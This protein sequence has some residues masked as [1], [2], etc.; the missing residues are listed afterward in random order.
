MAVQF[1]TDAVA[2]AQR[3]AQWQDIVCDVYVQLDCK[4]DLG[5]AFRGAITRVPLG[6]AACSTVSSDRQRVLRTP[7]RIAHA[8]EDFVLI[9]LG[10]H[11]RGAVL[12]DG[13]EAVI[14]AG[15]YALYDTTRPYELQ[16]DDAF[17]QTILQVPRAMLHRRIGGWENFTAVSFAMRSPIERLAFDFIASLSRIAGDI[18]PDNADRVTDQAL[19][20]VAMAIS[21][22]QGAATASPSTHRAA[23]LYRLKAHI[24]SHLAEPD[25]SPSDVAAAFGISPRYVNN[26][27]ADEHT[28]FQR[29]LLEQRLERCRRDLASPAH[30]PRQVSEIAF[31]WGFNDLSHFARVFRA[32][33]DVSPRECRASQLPRRS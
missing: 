22:L 10:R 27:L 25:L 28:S 17:E 11:G 5:S 24:Q 18:K 33:Y 9:A 31:A 32:R 14:N 4:S 26:L 13:R 20:L 15:E 2:P 12:Q 6:S 30:A 3:L 23:L 29:Y 19:D 1:S 7:S 21:E 16:F 8:Q